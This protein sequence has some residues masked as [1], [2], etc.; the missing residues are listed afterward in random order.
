MLSTFLRVPTLYHKVLSRPETSICGCVESTGREGIFT[1]NWHEYFTYDASA[2]RLIWKTRS[3]E[4][5]EKPRHAPHWNG[6]FSGKVAGAPKTAK[7]RS[8][9]RVFG[10]H[11]MAY[12]IIWEMHNGPIPEG[13]FVD[14]INRNPLD[15]RI[16]NLRLA[17]HSQNTANSAVSRRNTSGYKGVSRDKKINKWI[18]VVNDGGKSKRLGAYECIHDASEAYD[19]Y[20]KS[21]HG[22]FAYLNNSRSPK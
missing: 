15:D 21:K 1:M 4:S 20:A 16:E 22:E 13:M 17:N 2:G 5:F 6:R 18:V 10:M 8:M 9:V 11:L 14:H 19:E 7:H 3:P 12:R